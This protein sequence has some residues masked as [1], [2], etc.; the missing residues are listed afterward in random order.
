MTKKKHGVYYYV[1]GCC[2]RFAAGRLLERALFG[3]FLRDS[4]M[5]DVCDLCVRADPACLCVVCELIS[6]I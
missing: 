2:C 3:G 6:V 5:C 4:P 1:G